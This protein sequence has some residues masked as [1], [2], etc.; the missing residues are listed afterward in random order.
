MT[1]YDLWLN[2]GSSAASSPEQSETGNLA[3]HA[4]LYG[5][6]GERIQNAHIERILYLYKLKMATSLTF[7][8]FCDVKYYTSLNV[9][10]FLAKLLTPLGV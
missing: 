3:V 8:G 6:F 4:V 9:K 2:C 7:L 5:A 1:R 10:V